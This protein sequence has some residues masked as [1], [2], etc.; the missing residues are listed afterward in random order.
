[1]GYLF[2]IFPDD[3]DHKLRV[4][5]DIFT[6][7]GIIRTALWLSTILIGAITGLRVHVISRLV[8]PL[9]L[10]SKYGSWALLTGATDGVGLMYCREFAAKGLNMI[11]IGRS[12][13]KLNRVK[14]ELTAQNGDIEVVTV[15][16]DLNDDD[17]EMYSRIK[18]EIKAEERDIGILVNNVGVM[19]DS[20]NKFLDQPESS[21]WQ[22][23]KV[24]ILPVVMITRIVLPSML[25]KKRGLLINMSS[26]AAYQPLP[27][28]GLYSATKVSPKYCYTIFYSHK[29]FSHCFR[30]L[31]NGSLRA[32]RWST[33]RQALK[34]KHSFLIT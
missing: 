30:F 31:L 29:A 34:Y 32:Y 2:Q 18:A 16:A 15:L 8:S 3:I 4:L 14:E 27:L 20:P 7:L 28:M 19:Y 1:M 13:E 23:V 33:A 9:D 17:K 10:R 12:Q 24:N 26:I 22:Q 21:I 6:L 11:I 5:L 25:K